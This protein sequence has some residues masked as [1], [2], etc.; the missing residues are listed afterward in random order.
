MD[1]RPQAHDIIRTWLFSTVLRAHL[2]H[3]TLPWTDTLISEAMHAGEEKA[4]TLK[5]KVPV[6]IGYWTAWVR[7]DGTVMYTD[8]PYGFDRVQAGLRSKT[9]VRS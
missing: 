9:S 7:P 4:V 8:D 3:G 1:L 6:H 2:E 5:Q